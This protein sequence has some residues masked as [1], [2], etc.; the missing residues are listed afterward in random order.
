M[1]EAKRRDHRV[2]G[3]KLDLFSLQEDAGGG[4]VRSTSL[5]L[6]ARSHI[7]VLSFVADSVPGGMGVGF[8]LSQI[9]WI[10]GECLDWRGQ[11]LVVSA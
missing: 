1:V 11:K 6:F 3:K 5:L 2:L 4:L 10:G 7:I 8:L 9:S